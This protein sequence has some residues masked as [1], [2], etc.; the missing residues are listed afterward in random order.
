MI[1]YVLPWFFNLFFV[2][3]RWL[4]NSLFF[5][6]NETVFFPAFF[7]KRS[8]IK[9][10]EIVTCI[11]EL[12]QSQDSLKRWS[13]NT[14][15]TTASKYLTLLKK[16]GL[17]EGTVNKRI[18]QPYLSD[19]MFIRFTYWMVAISEKP[20][21]LSSNWII[22]SFSEK[23]AFLD[24]LFQKKFS[25]YFNLHYTGDNLMIQPILPYESIYEY[26]HNSWKS[27]LSGQENCWI[28]QTLWNPFECEWRKFH[29]SCLSPG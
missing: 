15:S 24:R 20:N 16:F 22:Y 18:K 3:Q 19:D 12:K 27:N 6:L 13:N 1:F 9:K 14:I 7:S 4:N 17:L 21:L 29:I 11:L 28:G 5:Y 2:F 8:V 25:K 10:D 26:S 23:Q